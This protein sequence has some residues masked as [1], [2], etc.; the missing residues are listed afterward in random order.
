MPLR[1]HTL[2]TPTMTMS[3]S[4]QPTSAPASPR[5]RPH[6]PPSPESP[7]L[8]HRIDGQPGLD[9]FLDSHGGLWR[10]G[11]VWEESTRVPHSGHH[12]HLRTHRGTPDRAGY[13]TYPSRAGMMSA[14]STDGTGKARSTTL[15]SCC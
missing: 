6:L 11:V 10:V 2:A 8:S 13:R 1:G 4:P 15:R 14:I 7:I 12:H 5:L 3:V 9:S